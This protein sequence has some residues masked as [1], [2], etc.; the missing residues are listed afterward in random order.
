[1]SSKQNS[2]DE[3][4]ASFS[5]YLKNNK[6]RN[7]LERDAIFDIIRMTK[8]PFSL[9]SVLKELEESNFRVSRASIYNTIE[10]LM[11]AKIVVRHQF[12]Y[13][14]VLY[15]LKHIADNHHYTICTNCGNVG[16][17]KN[18]KINSFF[19][20]YKIPKFDTEYY[21][22]YFYGICSKCKYRLIREEIKRNKESKKQK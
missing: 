3:L 5:E 21:S 9:D 22:M 19:S 16:K 2:S 18:E 11:N 6:L 7:T 12:T 17:I 14:N 15:E 10:L 20:G 8:E 4:K 13:T 1:M